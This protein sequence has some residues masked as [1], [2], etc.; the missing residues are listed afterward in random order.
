[1]IKRIRY[2]SFF[3]VLLLYATNSFSQSMV[4]GTYHSNGEFGGHEI[5][6]NS[7]MTYTEHI[8]GCVYETRF[9]GN[10]S[11]KQDSLVLTSNSRINLRT[12]VEY[13]DSTIIKKMI[14][15]QDSL[16]I[17]F[18]HDRTLAAIRSFALTKTK[19]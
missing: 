2:F 19:E 4:S 13:K 7:D 5:I 8:T 17:I 6:L 18:D 11:T 9:K 3:W 10:W 12:K 1:M 16:L 15:R 14:I